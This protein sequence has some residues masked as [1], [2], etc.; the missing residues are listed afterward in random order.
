MSIFARIKSR[1]QARAKALIG[2]VLSWAGV[3]WTSDLCAQLGGGPAR[4]PQGWLNAFK[5]CTQLRAP[6]N[7]IAEDVAAVPFHLKRRLP[8]AVVLNGKVP[9][10][11]VHEGNANAVEAWILRLLKQPNPRMTG[12]RFRWLIEV[13]LETVGYAPIQIIWETVR[14]NG[15][16][17]QFPAQL[18]P[19]PPHRLVSLPDE[20]KPYFVVLGARGQRVEI[21]AGSVIWLNLVDVLDPYGMGAGA[22]AAVDD[23]VS[24]IKYAGIWNNN[25]YRQGA[26]PGTVVGLDGVSPETKKHIQNEW[27]SKYTGIHNAHRPLFVEGKVSV[28]AFGP[29]HKEQDFTAT[30]QHL[31][32]RLRFNWGMPPELL[33]DVRNSNRATIQGATQVHQQGNLAPRVAFLQEHFNAYLMP[34]FGDPD[35]FLEWDNPVQ[36]TEELMHEKLSRGYEIGT[37]T[38]DQWLMGHDMDPLGEPWGNQ[39]NVPLNMQGH[40]IN[41]EPPVP[42]APDAAKMEAV[43]RVY[44]AAEALLGRDQGDRRNGAARNGAGVYSID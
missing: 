31:G 29:S 43:K 44:A 40:N 2:G 5:T 7:R 22:A 30:Q 25:F 10:E 39:I 33:G 35:L 18:K 9:A 41:D 42:Q 1:F 3:N 4:N 36:S 11:I 14:L 23:E 37:V 20:G 34:L 27:E 21:E 17:T 32:D 24:Q 12:T 26:H 16:K 38:R 13:Y 6:V 15:R 19:I 28:Q 8:G